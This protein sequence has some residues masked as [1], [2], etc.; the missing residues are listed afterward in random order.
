MSSLAKT[1]H[2]TLFECLF[3]VHEYMQWRIYDAAFPLKQLMV[4]PFVSNA[5]FPHPPS[6]NIRKP[7]G[8]SRGRERV[9]WERMG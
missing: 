3:S 7:Y 1:L 6:V 4:N 2:T 9:H 5:P 8:F